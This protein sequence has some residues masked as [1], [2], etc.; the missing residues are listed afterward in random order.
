MCSEHMEPDYSDVVEYER[1][2]GAEHHH[3]GKSSEGMLDKAAILTGL[4]IRSGQRVLD[5]GCGNGY[6]AKEFSR[7]VGAMGK[8]QA[9]DPDK[10]AIA[11]LRRETEG[12]NIEA[13]V[14]DITTESHLVESSLDLV[15]LSTVFHGFTTDQ[16]GGFEREVRRIL[17]PG[18]RLAVVEIIKC[19]TSFGPSLDRRYSPEELKGVLDLFPLA[20]VPVGEYFYM[21]LFENPVKD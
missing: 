3:R 8:V 14:G 18:G 12:T 10:V 2:S 19:D 21:Q 1:S 11:K 15:Y 16:V 13:F 6:M 9:L 17:K 5:A 20:T 4:G 7:T